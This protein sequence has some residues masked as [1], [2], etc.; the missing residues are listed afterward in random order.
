MKNASCKTAP[1]NGQSGM[2][3]LTVIL[4][5]AAI[6]VLAAGLYFMGISQ[7]I[8][9]RRQVRLEKAFSISEAGI[10]RAKAELMQ[11]GAGDSVPA[12]GILS[13]GPSVDFGGG[14][15]SVRA[16]GNTGNVIAIWSTGRFQNVERVLEVGVTRSAAQ[17][18]PM[19][20]DG[21]IAIYG[22]NIEIALHGSSLVDGRDHTVPEDFDCSGAG[23]TG[24]VIDENEE[25]AGIFSACLS[26]ELTV[27]GS[28]QIIGDPPM[29]SGTVGDY[30]DDYWNA[31]VDYLLEHA[32]IALPG[33]NIS[34]NQTIGTRDDPEIAV[35]TGNTRITGNVDGA[36]VLIIT[37]EI[38]VDLSGTF[39]YE[40]IIILAGHNSKLDALGNA[41]IFGSVIA[42]GE[43]AHIKPQGSPQIYYSTPAL[44]NLANLPMPP[45]P[46]SV[47]YW[48]HH[49]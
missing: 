48:R 47:A 25:T 3:L 41:A 39:H 12:D 35:I 22:P 24:S 43:D 38:E 11:M 18:P 21:A 1:R 15:Y 45:G 46:L 49:K 34:G 31:M 6:V 30:T 4:F 8:G 44:A 40:G 36:G 37:D 9:A 23:C 28:A 33:G 17:H 19:S 27:G 20:A 7:A 5:S 14:S 42:L 10:E 26:S 16:I 13:F 29:T 32:T 2:V